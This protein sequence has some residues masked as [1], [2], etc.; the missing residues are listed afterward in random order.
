MIEVEKKFQPTE[1]QNKKLL[2]GA[3][4][5]SHKEVVD[6]YYD[7]PS[8]EFAKKGMYLRNRDNSWELKIYLPSSGDDEAA[9]EIVD[10]NQILKSLGYETYQNFQDF[11]SQEL[12]ILGKILTDRKKYHK[13]GFILDFD[14]TDFGMKKLDIELQVSE[15]DQIPEANKKILDFINTFGMQEVK[16]PLK[17][18]AYLEK[19]RPEIYKQIFG[20]ENKKEL[21]MK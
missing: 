21:K 4:L 16:L 18:V 8:F 9:E 10:E 5:I 15:R 17:P 11:S 2:E 19:M 13:E 14:E 1:E 3:T 20:G 7:T 6:V 12:Q